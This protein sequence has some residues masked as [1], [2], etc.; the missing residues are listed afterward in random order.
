MV[1]SVMTPISPHALHQQA[2]FQRHNGGDAGDLAAQQ[3]PPRLPIRPAL[4]LTRQQRRRIQ[5]QP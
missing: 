1:K 4:G 5:T 2:G 3:A